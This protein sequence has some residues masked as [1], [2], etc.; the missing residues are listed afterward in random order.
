MNTLS[1]LTLLP[2]TKKEIQI[3]VEKAKEEILAGNEDA[4]KIEVQLKAFEEIIKFL[5]NDK[6]IKENALIEVEKYPN[7][8]FDLYGATIQKTELGTKYNFSEC[9]DL[10]LIK[11]DKKI[12][13]LKEEKKKKELFLK[14]LTKETSIVDNETGEVLNFFPPSKK[15][16]TGI[17]ITLK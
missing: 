1:T 6:E 13:L 17:K 12:E 14:T 4:L 7:K 5:R 15:S 9:N 10:D 16:T 11:I 2:S 3:F 8:S